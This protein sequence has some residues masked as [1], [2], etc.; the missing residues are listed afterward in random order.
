MWLN[1]KI[2]RLDAIDRI[3][4]LDCIVVKV[5]QDRSIINKSIFVVLGEEHKEFVRALDSRKLKGEVRSK[6]VDAA[7]K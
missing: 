7:A 2:D 6:C 3:V 4:Y 1:G 5:C